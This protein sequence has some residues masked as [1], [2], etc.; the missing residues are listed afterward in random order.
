MSAAEGQAVV[1]LTLATLKSLRNDS[2]FDL[3]WKRTCTAGEN[4]DINDPTLPLC[5]KI[6]RRLDDRSEQSFPQ[7]V[8]QHYRIGYFEALDLTI[9]CVS[10]RFD[11]PGYEMYRI[12]FLKLLNQKIIEKS[13]SL[14]NHFMA[15]MLIQYYFQLILKYFLMLFMSPRKFLSQIF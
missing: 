13:Y 8:E 12:Y 10:D 4:L 3:F 5:R 7:T 11:Q 1:S 15:Q 9:V 14:C 2:S 6:P